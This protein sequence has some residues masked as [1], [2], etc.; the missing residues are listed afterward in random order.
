MGITSKLFLA[1]DNELFSIAGIALIDQ[2]STAVQIIIK[3]L[4]MEFHSTTTME[5]PST[6]TTMEFHSTTTT[7]DQDFQAMEGARG[8]TTIQEEGGTTSTT[9]MELRITGAEDSFWGMG[10]EEEE[11]GVG[12]FWLEEA[13]THLMDLA[14]R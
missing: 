1:K 10:E 3:D 4:Q 12:G 5:I 6:T 8:F 2:G 11:E 9:A 14:G 13:T 7:M